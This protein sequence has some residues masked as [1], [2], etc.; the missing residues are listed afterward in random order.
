M[1]NYNQAVADT[2][3][4]LNNVI[5]REEL[6]DLLR[7]WRTTPKDFSGINT[8]LAIITKM[9][10]D[11]HEMSY[12]EDIDESWWEGVANQLVGMLE[13]SEKNISPRI[14]PESV[15]D[16]PVVDAD[17]EFDRLIQQKDSRELTPEQFQ[18]KSRRLFGEK[19]HPD[20]IHERA[21]EHLEQQRKEGGKADLVEVGTFGEFCGP[22]SGKPMLAEVSL[23]QAYINH[24]RKMRDQS[25]VM[26]SDAWNNDE[27]R[28][29]LHHDLQYDV[30]NRSL[31][32]AGIT[33]DASSSIWPECVSDACSTTQI[34]CDEH[35]GFDKEA[36]K[37][38]W[39]ESIQ[40]FM[41]EYYTQTSGNPFVGNQRIYNDETVLE[42]SPW[43]RSFEDPENWAVDLKWIQALEPGQ[44]QATRAM[45]WLTSL[46]DE[47]GVFI[48]LLAKPTGEP[49]IP[50]KKLKEFYGEHGF[51]RDREKY[52]SP[53]DMY[54]NP[55]IETTAS[56]EDLERYGWKIMDQRT[57]GDHQL[58]LTVHEAPEGSLPWDEDATKVYQVGL[59]RNGMDF[60]DLEQ[61]DE[62][63]PNPMPKSL[64]PFADVISEWVARYKHLLVKSHKDE[65]TEQYFKVLP[66][67]G[68]HVR[69]TQWMGF[70]TLIIGSQKMKVKIGEQ[71]ADVQPETGVGNSY[72]YTGDPVIKVKTDP[73]R[74]D[75]DN[76][77]V[78]DNQEA[79]RFQQE[80]SVEKENR[81]KVV[82]AQL[83]GLKLTAEQKKVAAHIEQNVMAYNNEFINT[84]GN[85]FKHDWDLGPSWDLVEADGKCRLVKKDITALDHAPET[86]HAWEP[87][88]VLMRHSEIM[89]EEVVVRE[90]LGENQY[91]VQSNLDGKI[92]VIAEDQLY[93][94]SQENLAFDEP[95]IGIG[96]LPGLFS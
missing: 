87:G 88:S 47:Y 43:C 18:Q 31:D 15:E 53:D 12:P 52:K 67:L 27:I 70:P 69:K 38:D 60:T 96:D 62:K 6:N 64:H 2:A 45:E 37:E 79:V 92:F 7:I 34:Y 68:L 8:D 84:V 17:K 57:V 22:L 55:S 89:P 76:A 81:L 58:T 72:E 90:C 3:F 32:A 56:I 74:S 19:N 66:R 80:A 33:G 25:I 4:T 51:E 54:R 82:R 59:Q 94:P 24:L 91:R 48:E 10:A 63:Y 50:K 85:L 14:G 44:G 95:V 35:L 1:S 42:V 75:E 71:W 21:A 23:V 49:K 36:A 40:A 78:V 46:A 29:D 61:Q 77:A 16:V 28:R 9:L 65:K 93:N 20:F 26:D 30:V 5:E 83:E 11:K 86:K 13:E 39:P 41:Q 73:H